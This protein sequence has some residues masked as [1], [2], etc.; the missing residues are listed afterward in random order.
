MILAI[1]IGIK[2]LGY[3]IY[4]EL[5]LKF[6]L[7]NINQRNKL[8][9]PIDRI[10]TITKFIDGILSKYNITKLVIEQQI[11]RNIICLELQ[12]TLMT[13]GVVN[14][15]EVLLFKPNL[16]FKYINSIYNTKR[17]EHKKLSI[18]YASNIIKHLGYSLNYFNT[19]RKRDDI[20]DAICMSVMSYYDDRSLITRL[21][22]TD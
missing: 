20:S 3:A 6:G 10:R 14:D 16:K 13:L 4:E 12:Y 17:K 7:F 2:N 8:I 22:K 15:I 5:D 21:I 1:D 11:S 9:K 18:Q 19:F